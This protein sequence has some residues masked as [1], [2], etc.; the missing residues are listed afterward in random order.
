MQSKK[1]SCKKP[2]ALLQKLLDLQDE[3]RVKLHITTTLDL[4]EQN[5]KKRGGSE[6]EI[7]ELDL[8]K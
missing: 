4:N 8:A 1:I 3:F 7:T 6:I 5:H 2:P